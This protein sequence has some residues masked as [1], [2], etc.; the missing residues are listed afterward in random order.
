MWYT[1]KRFDFSAYGAFYA[2]GEKQLEEELKGN[3]INDYYV[4]DYWLYYRKDNWKEMFDAFKKHGEN[5]RKRR[6]KEE[7]LEN[8]IK[9]E[10]NNHE[11]YY[12]WNL[13][14]AIDALSYYWVDEKEVKKV[15]DKNKEFYN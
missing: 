8:I 7:G 2:F 11:A 10:L 9:Y 1:E 4:T 6:V 13:S 3:N 14:D 15:Y 5:E 12:T